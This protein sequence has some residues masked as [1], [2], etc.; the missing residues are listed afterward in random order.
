MW[1]SQDRLLLLS[2]IC[3]LFVEKLGSQASPELKN[4]LLAQE[5]MTERMLTHVRNKI[6]GSW[7]RRTSNNFNRKSAI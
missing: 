3:F 6:H 4:K 1:P 2:S 5:L 7:D